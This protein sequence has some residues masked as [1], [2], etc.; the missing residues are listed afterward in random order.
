MITNTPKNWAV[1]E[2]KWLSECVMKRGGKEQD[3]DDAVFK[4]SK[5]KRREKKSRAFEIQHMVMY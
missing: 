3:A 4:K 2:H 5:Q 1:H